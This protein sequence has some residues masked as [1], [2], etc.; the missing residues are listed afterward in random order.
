MDASFLDDAGPLPILLGQTAS[1]KGAAACA[2]AARLPLEIVSVDSMKVYRGM[3]IGTAKPSAAARRAVPHHLLDVADPWESYHAARFLENAS[4]ATRQIRFRRRTPLHVGG[5]GLYLRLLARGLFAGPPRDAAVRGLLESR[6]IAGELPALHAELAAGDP[7]TAARLH[8]HDAKRIVRALEVLL[9]SGR[10]ISSF[11]TQ[12]TDT[13]P[14]RMRL[15]GLR[16]PVADLDR[17]IDERVDR[18]F[19]AGLVEEVRALLADPHGLSREAAQA[20]GYREVAEL[21][22]GLRSLPDTVALVKQRTRRFARR[23]M[24]WFRSFAEIQWIDLRPGDSA[25]KAAEGIE[26]ALGG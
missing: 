7:P 2:L 9:A 11:Q 19:A 14:G 4:E 1:G 25:V 18:M 17:R 22:A 6:V 13:P 20:L 15:V 21:L 26:R 16:W 23:Q 3:D 24:T 10:P 5:T 12:P 8:P